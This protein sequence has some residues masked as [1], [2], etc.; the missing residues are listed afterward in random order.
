MKNEHTITTCPICGKVIKFGTKQIAQVNWFSWEFKFSEGGWGHSNTMG[1]G[2]DEI[3]LECFEAL[4]IQAERFLAVAESRRGIN[5]E[6]LQIVREGK[7]VDPPSIMQPAPELQPSAQT[8]P[9]RHI[10]VKPAEVEVGFI[11]RFL[12]YLNELLGKK[13]KNG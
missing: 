12:Q 9:E 2:C 1:S 7:P 13:G 3:C 5:R 10:E 4:L 6:T 11:G 8:I